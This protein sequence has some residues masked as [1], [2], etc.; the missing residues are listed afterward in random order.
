M[1]PRRD[2]ATEERKKSSAGQQHHP[3]QATRAVQGRASHKAAIYLP[4]K[5]GALV[6]AVWAHLTR[7]QLRSTSCVV[8]SLPDNSQRPQVA[9]A[10]SK[11]LQ[12]CAHTHALTVSETVT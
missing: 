10:L 7:D 5:T 2:C 3:T 1:P 11:G 4:A 9:I 12:L 8:H 6:S